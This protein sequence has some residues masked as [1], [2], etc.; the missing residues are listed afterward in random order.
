M[1]RKPNPMLPPACAALVPSPQKRQELDHALIA[2][3]VA[4]DHRIKLNEPLSSMPPETKPQD[5]GAANTSSW[6]VPNMPRDSKGRPYHTAETL[7]ED[8][9][10][11]QQEDLSKVKVW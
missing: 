2:G 9:R 8:S 11:M 1:N 3:G 6:R 7:D 5:R 4:T 10:R